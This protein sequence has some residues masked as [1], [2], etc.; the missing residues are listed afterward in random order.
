MINKILRSRN[1]SEPSF[2]GVQSAVVGFDCV[3]IPPT[4]FLAPAISK[5]KSVKMGDTVGFSAKEAHSG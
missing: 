4:S 1:S 5:T 3:F 2:S